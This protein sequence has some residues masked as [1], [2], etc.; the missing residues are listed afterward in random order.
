MHETLAQ[1]IIQ[2][3]R[4]VPVIWKFVTKEVVHMHT[5]IEP[6]PEIQFVEKTG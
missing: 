1:E 2:E 6:R 4:H 5:V 3:V